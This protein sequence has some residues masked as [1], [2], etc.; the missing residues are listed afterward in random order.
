V[1]VLVS[2]DGFGDL[3]IVVVC[4]IEWSDYYGR[5]GISRCAIEERCLYRRCESRSS[6]I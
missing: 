4:L 2:L 6:R 1:G 3:S 5:L